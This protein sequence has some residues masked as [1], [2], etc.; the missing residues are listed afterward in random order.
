MA[1]KVVYIFYSY[2]FVL[3]IV[4][5][6]YITAEHN[7]G[8]HQKDSFCL[9]IT[10]KSICLKYVHSGP[11]S[12]AIIS[13]DWC[14][15]LGLYSLLLVCGDCPLTLKRGVYWNLIPDSLDQVE[16]QMDSNTIYYFEFQT[17][18]LDL[19]PV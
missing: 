13:H 3:Y 16:S 8:C 6:T 5:F 14:D 4:P 19:Q 17:W 7:H 15:V 11:K 12:K 2:S 1:V 18:N 10:T 9:F